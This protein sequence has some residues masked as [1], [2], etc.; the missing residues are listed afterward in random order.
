MYS[1]LEDAKKLTKRF[2]YFSIQEKQ[3]TLRE[4]KTLVRS[5]TSC[6]ILDF[7]DGKAEGVK[8]ISNIEGCRK[9]FF[10]K[11][12]RNLIKNKAIEI[13]NGLFYINTEKVYK[14]EDKWYYLK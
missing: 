1:P 9:D 4:N 14:F 8:E 10:N 2:K 3:K 5:L 6:I 7:M 11:S 12:L 13:K